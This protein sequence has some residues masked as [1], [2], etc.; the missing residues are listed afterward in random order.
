MDSLVFLSGI[1][2]DNALPNN[3]YA[4]IERERNI[5]THSVGSAIQKIHANSHFM[6]DMNPVTT[7][8]AP[9]LLLLNFVFPAPLVSEIIAPINNLLR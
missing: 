3:I 8:I 2:Q 5:A 6:S 7:L 9:T 1:F 4:Y